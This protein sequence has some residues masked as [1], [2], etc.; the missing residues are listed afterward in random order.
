[1]APHAGAETTDPISG[2]VR[3]CGK[4][5]TQLLCGSRVVLIDCIALCPLSAVHAA[6]S[7][8]S[9]GQAWGAVPATWGSAMAYFG[10]WAR[11]GVSSQFSAR[12]EGALCWLAGRSVVL[13]GFVVGFCCRGR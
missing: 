6:S 12:R 13:G 5:A 8:G 9:G 3:A 7:T 10:C 11:A 1:M 2:K 4:G